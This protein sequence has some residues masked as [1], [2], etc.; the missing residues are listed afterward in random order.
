MVDTFLDIESPEYRWLLWMSDTSSQN[1]VDAAS[2]T[3]AC[4]ANRKRK[5]EDLHGKQCW[6]NGDLRR[7]FVV[8]YIPY[9]AEFRSGVESS[10]SC[11]SNLGYPIQG[12]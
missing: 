5:I 1:L 10:V 9:P 8:R 3:S 4:G 7:V 11:Y 2:E 6:V 12:Q